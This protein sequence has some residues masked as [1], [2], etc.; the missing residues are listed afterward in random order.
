MQDQNP[1]KN[2]LYNI[3]VPLP[4]IKHKDTIQDQLKTAHDTVVEVHPVMTTKNTIDNDLLQELA[5]I[6]IELPPP[7]YNRSRYDNY[8]RDSRSYRSPYRS[9]YKSPHRRDSRSRYKSRSYSKDNTFPRYTSSHRLPSRPRDSRYSRSRS[10]S[11]TRNKINNIQPQGS[12]DPINFEIHLY[13]PT[14]MANALTPTSW[15]YSLYTHISSD[16][17]HRD[18]PSRL[19]VSFLL[20]SGA[21]I[22][23]LNHPTYI[24]IAKLLI[25][26]QNPPHNSS[27]TLTVANQ[28]GVPTLHYITIT[29]NTTIEDNSRQFTIPFA[30][31]DIK[32]N[33]LGTPFFEENFQNI[34]IQ[35]FTLQFKHHS[36]VYPNYA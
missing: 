12:T 6:T 7:H 5:M 34:N 3:S 4:M 29:L 15:F 25:F 8:H 30:V 28:T 33:I 16:Q 1:L 31:A 13:H 27:K 36:R 2:L 32:Y 22:S 17:N 19:K 10:H 35:D 26:K 9:S 11:Q 24:T 14:E 20:D 23:V 21:S 18:Y